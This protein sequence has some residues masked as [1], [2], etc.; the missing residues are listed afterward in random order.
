MRSVS[1]STNRDKRTPKLSLCLS[2]DF[3]R[4]FTYNFKLSRSEGSHKGF[5]GSRSNYVDLENPIIATVLDFRYRI[6][7]NIFLWVDKKFLWKVSSN[8]HPFWFLF[9]FSWRNTSSKLILFQFTYCNNFITYYPCFTDF[10]AANRKKR[11]GN[12]NCEKSICLV[13]TVSMEKKIFSSKLSYKILISV[14]VRCLSLI[15][16]LKIYLHVIA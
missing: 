12:F 14:L 1:A 7:V 2:Q 3:Q 10:I 9:Y 5:T 6:Y 8:Q 11:N 13:V 16:C 15:N 4:V